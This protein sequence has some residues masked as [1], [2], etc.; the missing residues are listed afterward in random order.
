ML[1]S[2]GILFLWGKKK[3]KS[4]LAKEIEKNACI[5]ELFICI[6]DEI[7][8]YTLYSDPSYEKLLGGWCL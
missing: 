1:K 8:F 5:Y 3:K 7:V 2:A 6:S 4:R